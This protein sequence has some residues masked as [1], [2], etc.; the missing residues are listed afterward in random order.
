MPSPAAQ[1]AGTLLPVSRRFVITWSLFACLWA[2]WVLSSDLS[3]EGLAP[4]FSE[5]PPFP[6]QQTLGERAYAEALTAYGLHRIERNDALGELWSLAAR[7]FGPPVVIVAM[8]VIA[9]MGAPRF[10]DTVNRVRP[11]RAGSRA[12]RIALLLWATLSALW[13]ASVALRRGPAQ[14]LSSPGEALV[15]PMVALMIGLFVYGV[16]LP[17]RDRA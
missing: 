11:L 13:V 9:D 5:A 16:S 7:A 3:L 15:P 2:A 12:V 14:I 1:Q 6:D 8:L 17:V 10:M 4:L